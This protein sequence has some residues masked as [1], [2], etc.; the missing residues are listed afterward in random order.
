MAH[1]F[2]RSISV[3]AWIRGLNSI[4]LDP[5]DCSS[6]AECVN[7][8]AQAAAYE[9]LLK[10]LY[11]H[12]WFNG[13][14][15]ATMPPHCRQ[16]KIHLC[17]RPSVHAWYSHIH[18]WYS[19]HACRDASAPSRALPGTRCCLRSPA[20]ALALSRARALVFSTSRSLALANRSRGRRLER[21]LVHPAEQEGREGD[22][23]LV[24]WFGAPV[25]GH[26]LSACTFD[27]ADTL[28]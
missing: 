11:P 22:E 10:A 24:W 14:C 15:T 27:V 5:V 18:A 6:T 13:V 9:G 4:E 2:A 1:L 28:H 25:T 19:V 3:Q 8:D 26:G 20:L 21:R 16:H 23:R 7:Q 17:A 12:D